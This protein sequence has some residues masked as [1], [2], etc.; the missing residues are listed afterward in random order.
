MLVL[1]RNVN[2]KIIITDKRTGERIEIMVTDILNHPQYGKGVKLSID[3]SRDYAI[4]RAEL[5]NFNKE[6]ANDKT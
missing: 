3:A 2:E 5:Y 6:V 4:L 1:G